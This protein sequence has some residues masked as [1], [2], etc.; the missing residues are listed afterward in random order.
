MQGN[1]SDLLHTTKQ[2]RVEYLTTNAMHWREWWV[3][4]TSERVESSTG[5]ELEHEQG[6]REGRPYNDDV[7]KVSVS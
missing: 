1:M 4:V 2:S 6:G 7:T 5:W 3:D